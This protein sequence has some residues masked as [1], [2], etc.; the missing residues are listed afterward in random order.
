MLTSKRKYFV[1]R[2]SLLFLTASSFSLDIFLIP[3]S[4]VLALFLG[5]IS[6]PKNQMAAAQPINAAPASNSTTSSNAEA[7][8]SAK[9]PVSATIASD[10]GEVP[11][12]I[13]KKAGNVILKNNKQPFSY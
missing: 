12:N 6:S 11:S 8:D 13:R 3:L 10:T 2:S 9:D 7:I 5:S 1:Q 4:P